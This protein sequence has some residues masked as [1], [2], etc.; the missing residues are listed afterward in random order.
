ML[1]AFCVLSRKSLPNLRY[2]NVLLSFFFF[3]EDISYVFLSF[4]CLWSLYFHTMDLYVYSY[5]NATLFSDW[6]TESLKIRQC[7]SS[8]FI[9]QNYLGILYP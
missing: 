4:L 9:F 5:T 6:L 8:K 2:R 7:K 3:S 1:N